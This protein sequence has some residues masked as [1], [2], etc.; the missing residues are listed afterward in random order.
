MHE[1]MRKW[2]GIKAAAQISGLYLLGRRY[3]IP[4]AREYKAGGMD[5]IMSIG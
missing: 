3:A 1:G 4:S 2:E 5:Q